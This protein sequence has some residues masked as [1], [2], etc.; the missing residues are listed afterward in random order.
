MY[1]EADT[2]F[3]PHWLDKAVWAFSRLSDQPDIYLAE[4]VMGAGLVVDIGMCYR[5][6][7][8]RDVVGLVPLEPLPGPTWLVLLPLFV[9]SFA[10]IHWGTH[11]SSE[12]ETVRLTGKKRWAYSILGLFI[13]F[14]WGPIGI[15]IVLGNGGL[16]L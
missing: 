9:L 8:T 14:G 3:C 5:F 13:A 16:I 2:S 1:Q 6:L 12:I 15:L 10:L 7:V 4:W 11:S